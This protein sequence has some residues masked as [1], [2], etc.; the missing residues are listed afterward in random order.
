MLALLPG[1]IRVSI[2]VRCFG[3]MEA[4]ELTVKWAQ[5]REATQSPPL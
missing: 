5:E 4:V 1:M 2:C 3:K